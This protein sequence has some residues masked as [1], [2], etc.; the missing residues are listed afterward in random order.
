MGAWGIMTFEDDTSLDL[1]DEWVEERAT[2]QKISKDIKTLLSQDEFDYEA[3]QAAGAFAAVIEFALSP[4][5]APDFE[6]SKDTNEGLTLWLSSLSQDELVKSIPLAVLGV[7]RMC[8]Q[9]SELNELWEESGEY[10]NQW[11][12]FNEERISRLKMISRE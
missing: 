2:V 4:A 11:L 3:G 7:Q 12:S 10:Y 9:D 5:T 1:L 8:S 6:D